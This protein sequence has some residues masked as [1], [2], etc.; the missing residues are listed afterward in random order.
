MHRSAFHGRLAVA[1]LLAGLTGIFETRAIAQDQLAPH[2]ALKKARS[3]H[4]GRLSTLKS[5]ADKPNA[6]DKEALDAEA[7]FYVYRFSLPPTGGETMK[8]IIAY[9]K[10][11]VD[12]VNQI[13]SNTDP[14]VYKKKRPFVQQ[15]SPHL[16]QRF[17]DLF[18]QD[19]Q[20]YRFAIV[21]AAPMLPQA[22]RMKDDAIGLYLADLVAGKK[23]DVIKMYAARGLRE[24]FP[25]APVEAGA[26]LAALVE[27]RKDREVKYVDAL[28]GF[29]ERKGGDKLSE[30]EE[31]AIRYLRRESLESLAQTQAP[32]IVSDKVKVEGPI[33]PTL[34]RILAPKGG[35]EPSPGLAERIEAAIGVCQI[36]YAQVPDYQPEIGTY[37]VGLFVSELATEY[38]KDLVLIRGGKQ[39]LLP[40]KIH[41]KRLENALKDLAKNAKNQPGEA[42]A[43][44]VA[45]NAIPLIKYMQSYNQITQPDVLAFTKMVTTLRPTL[46]EV[47]KGNK[48]F[49]IALD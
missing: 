13:E 37:L 2:D 28:A 23:H 5:G 32:A 10:E 42:N 43:K 47:Y 14:D 35:I 19:F 40:W 15:F 3:D 27:K 49:V 24:F 33:A 21:N 48:K 44:K 16:V 26:V 36:K 12:F 39:P 45:D 30:P 25:V 46:T 8:G 17:K 1:L 38:N 31:N 29:I 9:Q 34:L 20:V 22:A 7:K 41:S 6:A 18:D 4:I 11:F